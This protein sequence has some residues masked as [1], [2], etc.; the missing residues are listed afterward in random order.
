MARAV[1]TSNPERR[2]AFEPMYAIDAQT[3]A[4][5]EIFFADLVLASSFQAFGPG[6]FH[7]RCRPG[8]L[9]ECPPAGPF[10][11]AYLAYRHALQGRIERIPTFG[12][13]ANLSSAAQRA[14]P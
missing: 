5:I 4:T 12:R 14:K 6:W 13:R 11:T 3:G 10:D 8:C 2:P 1:V 9:P 7:W